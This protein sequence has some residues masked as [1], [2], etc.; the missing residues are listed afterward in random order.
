MIN[1]LVLL[2]SFI[3]GIFI[4]AWLRKKRRIKQLPILHHREK[5]KAWLQMT[6]DERKAFDDYEK[7]KSRHRKKI[8]LQEIRKEYQ[9]VQLVYN[10]NKRPPFS[11]RKPKE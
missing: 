4:A 3:A 2:F 6:R 9:K 10:K 8:L 11:P 1:F 5:M 7:N